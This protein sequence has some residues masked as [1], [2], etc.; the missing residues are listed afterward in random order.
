[1]GE[2]A[3]S[4]IDGEFDYITGEYIGPGVGYPRTMERPRKS[5]IQ[6]F[7]GVFGYL[8]KHYKGHLGNNPRNPHKM[9]TETNKIMIR[10]LKENNLRHVDKGS[11]SAW[12]YNANIVQDYWKVFKKWLSETLTN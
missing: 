7:N 4:L 12:H 8:Q 9:A 1:M 2:I 3:E 6:S 11:Y 10:F 5:G